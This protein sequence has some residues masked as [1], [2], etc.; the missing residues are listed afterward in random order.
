MRRERVGVRLNPLLGRV[1][2]GADVPRP[3]EPFGVGRSQGSVT[4]AGEAGAT[5]CQEQ[6]VGVD[7]P[8]DVDPASG[9]VSSKRHHPP[10][11]KVS[12]R[13]DLQH[14]L[15]GPV[16]ALDMPAGRLGAGDG[17]PF[18]S[19][20]FHQRKHASNPKDGFPGPAGSFRHGSGCLDGETALNEVIGSVASY[21]GSSGGRRWMRPGDRSVGEVWPVDGPGRWGW[22]L[23]RLGWVDLVGPV[24]V[25]HVA[26]L[27]MLGG[28]ER[29]VPLLVGSAGLLVWRGGLDVLGGRLPSRPDR[30]SGEGIVSF[31]RGAGSLILSGVLVGLDGGTESP[32]FFSML[33]VLTWETIRSPLRRVVPLGAVALLVYAAVIVVVPDVTAKS[34]FRLV[35][36]VV[37]IGLL[38]WARALTEQWQTASVRMQN[39]VTGVV[40]T[41]PLGLGVYEM[42]ALQCVLAN[43]SAARLGLETPD[44]TM[45]TPYGSDTEVTVEEVLTRAAMSEESNAA[46]LYLVPDGDGAGSFVRIGVWSEQGTEG[47]GRLAV[48]T[49]DVTDQVTVGEQHRRFLQSANHQFRTPL[50]P[51]LAYSEMI[52][53]G[54]LSGEALVEAATA[55]RE[56]AIQIEHLLNRIDTLIRLQ[57]DHYRRSVTVTVAELIDTHL[58]KN[59]PDHIDGLRV[60]GDTAITIRC[61]PRTLA[62]ALGELVENGHR[63]GIPPVTLTARRQD[64]QVHLRVSD[65]GPG[66]DIDPEA[67]LDDAWGVLSCPEMMPPE[68]GTRLGLSYAHALAR[69]ADATLRFERNPGDWAFVLEI[70]IAKVARPGLER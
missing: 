65:Q 20:E 21:A 17:N 13:T 51:M 55:I 3:G 11:M 39:L 16:T 44:R 56:G 30:R 60:E 34:L 12:V 24:V 62:M 57:G 1:C 7:R 49:E 59:R 54:E 53:A 27:A 19:T 61:E 10:W 50:S 15:D 68:M 36:F 2:R 43:E 41:L 26:G 67:L 48:Y 38:T 14:M 8:G 63:H 47:G 46:G 23:R 6:T 69:I 28:V 40:E 29:P 42:P 4:F 5:V 52:L 37:F 31:V 45:L 25:F 33:I 18:M 35:M 58:A 66:P 22:W 64:R 9:S 32:L 70:P